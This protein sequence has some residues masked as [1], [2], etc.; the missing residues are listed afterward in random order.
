MKERQ[1]IKYSAYAKLIMNPTCNLSFQQAVNFVKGKKHSNYLQV[2][3]TRKQHK[4]F[5]AGLTHT[6]L[7]MGANLF[8]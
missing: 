3:V 1:K 4:D 8:V 5:E 6:V 2:P 7:A